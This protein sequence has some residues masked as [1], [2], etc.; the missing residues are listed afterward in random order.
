MPKTILITGA[1]DGIGQ[2]AALSL[3][4][5]GHTLLIHGR[6]AE[7]LTATAAQL[8]A[9][10]GAGPVETWQ[11]DLSDLDATAR[12][13]REIRAAH[14]QIDVLINNA[15]I[16]KTDHPVMADGQDVRFVVNTLAPALL[17]R[18]L[19][20]AIPRD[21]RI[22]HLSSA[23]QA[24]VDLQALAGERPLEPMAAYAQSKLALT[25]WSQSLA[26]D[27][28]LEGP[29]TIAVNPGSLLATNMVRKGFGVAGNDIGI[30]A[31]IL[32]RAALSDEFAGATGRYYDNDSHRFAAP[33]GEAADAGKVARV[34]E[35]IEARI[36]GYLGA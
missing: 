11:A 8:R 2:A 10:P 23:A 15:G 18:L 5:L 14:G 25:E 27:L 4:A 20:G 9:L 34:V 1:T 17:T 6:S 28:G 36:A 31:D 33:H 29:A 3:G 24:P 12:L 30:G 22:I 16:Y 7:K 35:A 13:G 32:T 26:A 19:L 21:G